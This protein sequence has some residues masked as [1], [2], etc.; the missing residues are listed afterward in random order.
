MYDSKDND[1]TILMTRHE[2]ARMEQRIKRNKQVAMLQMVV[3]FAALVFS[4]I[5]MSLE[6]IP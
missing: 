3:G 2:R 6:V 5:I 4:V 1:F